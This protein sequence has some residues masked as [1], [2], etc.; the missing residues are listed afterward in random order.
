MRRADEYVLHRE[1]L[2]IKFA[3]YILIRK[4]IIANL[5][6]HMIPNSSKFTVDV[7]MFALFVF[8]PWM[9]MKIS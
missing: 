2:F 3:A 9:Q 4:Y 1:R 8:S 7:P 6:L 5:H